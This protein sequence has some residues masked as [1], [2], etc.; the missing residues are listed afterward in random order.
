MTPR[1]PEKGAISQNSRGPRTPHGVPD[2]HILSGPLSRERIETP[3]GGVR[4]RHV[5]AG[6]DTRAT[7]SFLGKTR[8]PTAFNAVNEGALYCRA[9]GDFCQ[10]VLLTPRYQG[11]Q[12][13]RWC[14]PRHT[15][16]SA[17]PARHDSSATEYHNS[18]E[19]D[20]QSTP[21][22]TLPQ[23]APHRWERRR[24]PRS[25]SLQ[26]D[27]VYPARDSRSL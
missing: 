13:S 9:R 19:V 27:E 5:S 11:V 15:R 22:P 4:S 6:A 24:P 17:M 1:V 2:P 23:R 10:A 16:Q 7:P 8:P 26:D 3:P 20:P 14:H 12:C 25:E 21:Q 18:Y